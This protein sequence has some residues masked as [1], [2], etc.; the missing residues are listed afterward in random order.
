MA[1]P[2]KEKGF[3]MI[4]HEILE[5]LARHPLAGRHRRI[6]DL[7]LRESYGRNRKEAFL[8]LRDFSKR[9]RIAKA[10]CSSLLRELGLLQMVTGI[11]VT[12]NGNHQKTA[13][14]FQ[15]D[16]DGWGVPSTVTV[17]ADGNGSVPKDGNGSR[18]RAK[19]REKRTKSTQ[20]EVAVL[21]RQFFE[22]LETKLGE[23]A[24]AFPGAMLGDFF[25]RT[26]NKGFSKDTIVE[27]ISHWFASTEPFIQQNGWAPRLFLKRFNDLRAGPLAGKQQS[28]PQSA[29]P[30]PYAY[31]RTAKTE[32]AI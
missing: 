32:A 29:A 1:S 9:T 13:W 16:F 3:T 7:I 18:T 23:K 10:H 5:A 30:D 31:L 12:A 27:R 20:P 26:L 24:A 14:I 21:V 8:S 17:T 15:K 6:L 19:K 2:Q 25:K 11:R 22:G 4:A 28:A